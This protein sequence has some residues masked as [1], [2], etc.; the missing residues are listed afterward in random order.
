MK[1]NTK[2]ILTAALFVLVLQKSFLTEE[3]A[4][5]TDEL[6]QLKITLLQGSDPTDEL[7]PPAAGKN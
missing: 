4:P 6:L 7:P 5:S 3:P 1:Q 2:I